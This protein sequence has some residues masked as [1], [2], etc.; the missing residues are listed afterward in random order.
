MVRDGARVEKRLVA[1]RLLFGVL[2]FGKFHL[3]FSFTIGVLLGF[4]LL[5]VLFQSLLFRLEIDRFRALGG[6]WFLRFFWSKL[7]GTAIPNLQNC[8][9]R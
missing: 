2:E 4:R 9:R 7:S 5:E 1:L 3:E 6:F 8:K